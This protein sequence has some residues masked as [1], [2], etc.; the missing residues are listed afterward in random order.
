MIAVLKKLG[1]QNTIPPQQ[2]DRYKTESSLYFTSIFH[3]SSYTQDSIHEQ[4]TLRIKKNTSKCRKKE[5]NAK[6]I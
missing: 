5:T 2:Q 3:E 6:I 1:R 4:H